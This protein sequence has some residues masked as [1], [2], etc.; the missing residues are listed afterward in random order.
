MIK[1]KEISTA[2][3]KAHVKDIQIDKDYVISWILFGIANNT[4][5]K[6]SLIFKGGTVLKKAYFPAYRFPDELEFTF[7][8]DFIAE[9]IKTAF[10]ETI[11]WVHKNPEIIF[12]WRGGWREDENN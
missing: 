7:K 4:F 1:A 12:S 3:S 6:E 8:G 9:A 5:L 11:T 10:S 2:A